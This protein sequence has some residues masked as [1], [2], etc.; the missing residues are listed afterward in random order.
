M[1]ALGLGNR[2]HQ[3]SIRILLC[4]LAIQPVRAQGFSIPIPIPSFGGHRQYTP[5]GQ[6]C[7][8]ADKLIKQGNLQAA[9]AKLQQAVALEPQKTL[10]RVNLGRALDELGH[11]TDAIQQL[12]TALALD[13]TDRYA[14]V[15]LIAAYVSASRLADAIAVGQAF[16]SRFPAD[17]MGAAID[18]EVQSAQ[19]ELSRRQQANQAIGFTNGSMNYP[20]TDNYFALTTDRGLIRW[21]F[22]RMPLKV[23]IPSGKQ[24]KYVRPEYA[25]VLT[26]AFKE[27]QS[28]TGGNISFVFIDEAAPADIAIEWNDDYKHVIDALELGEARYDKMESDHEMDHVTIAMLTHNPLVGTTLDPQQV[29]S[30]GLHEIGHALGLHGHSDN[31][32]D[33]M[34]FTKNVS[35]IRVSKRDVNTLKMI[36]IAK[37]M[38]DDAPIAV[39]SSAG[40]QNQYPQLQAAVQPAQAT[41][42]PPSQYGY[43]QQPYMQAMNNNL[44]AQPPPN[45]YAQPNSGNGP[46]VNQYPRVPNATQRP[47]GTGQMQIAASP[48]I[49]GYPLNQTNQ[50]FQS[51]QMHASRMPPNDGFTQPTPVTSRNPG[52]EPYI[53]PRLNST[54][55]ADAI[56]YMETEASS[57]PNDAAALLDLSVAYN[58]RANEIL[59]TTADVAESERL[60]RQALNLQN[61][62]RNKQL[63]TLHNLCHLL[64]LTDRVQESQELQASYQNR[65]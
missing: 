20:Q 35:S 14:Y 38:P 12:E 50:V 39:A 22:K 8:D 13:P 33:I 30:V 42:M 61:G 19:T 63:T 15:N 62:D 53:D 28:A 43:T 23:F 1:S 51:N 36:Y 31:P 18:A 44:P 32:S 25:N 11:T 5:Y 26:E 41:A 16:H 58:N 34:Y 65:W 21:S 2:I 56:R 7:V 45:V 49:T 6:L 40:G 29:H 37:V 27:W 24:G 9:V 52:Y 47:N 57:R 46:T 48:P 59:N 60:F 55:P 4:L 17:K 3:F 10:A 64:E 54:R